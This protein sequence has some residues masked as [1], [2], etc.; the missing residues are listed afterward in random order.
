MKNDYL[1]PST[2]SGMRPSPGH[3]SSTGPMK[4]GEMVNPPRMAEFGGM[5]KLNALGF[6]KNMMRIKKPGG[7]K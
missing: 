4:H 3:D 6:F 7:E 1:A 5:R 2:G